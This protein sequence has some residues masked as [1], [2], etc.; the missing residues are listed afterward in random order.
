MRDDVIIIG[1]GAGGLAAAIR[2]ARAGRRVTLIDRFARPG[3]KMRHTEAGGRLISNGPT[4]CTMRW[5]VDGLLREGGMDPETALQMTPAPRLARHA[6]MDGTRLDLFTSA[7]ASAAAIETAFGAREAD[8][9]LRFAQ[10][11]AETH[12]ILKDTFMTA[13][14][15]GPLGLMARIGLHRPGAMLKTTPFRSLTDELRRYFKDPR[16]IQLFGRYATYVGSSP[17]LA[18]A[19]LKVIAHTEQEGVWL[20]DGGMPALAEA[21][22]KAAEAQGARFIP[23]TTVSEI[24][25]EHGCAAGIRTDRGE[26][27]AASNILFNG[28]PNMLAQ[29]RLGDGVTSAVPALPRARRSL[30]ATTLCMVA[31]TSGFPLDYHTVF[32]G[33]D[34]QDEFRA[35]FDRREE[36]PLPTLYIC[37]E[38][39]RD[40]HTSGPERI[41]CLV[42]APP[43]GDL[44]RPRARPEEARDHIIARLAQYG[45]T[46]RTT[47]ADAVITTPD[48]FHTDFPGSGGSLY[49]SVNHGPFDSF[50]RHGA[51]TRLP[52]L[53]L[54]GGACHPGAGVPMAMLSG[55]L[56]AD[57]ILQDTDIR[58][59]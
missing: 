56:A 35:I 14:K 45:L 6:W 58:A 20:V 12:A 51:T 17:Y 3:G 43:D 33:E 27:L 4:V 11:A 32:F 25:I 37:A 54:A 53:Y 52:G 48:D 9:Y 19:T 24:I 42:N 46:L 47:P 7:Q 31:E 29:G 38:D 34:Y 13:P 1:A 59:R 41:F 23:S 49:G 57:Q 16:L 15:T 36:T 26:T 5:V 10:D 40:G 28:D 18:P 39:R 22:L 55:L 50:R 30:S 2:L 21:F 8:A 44:D